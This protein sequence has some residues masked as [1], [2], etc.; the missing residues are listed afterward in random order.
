MAYFIE[1]VAGLAGFPA[2][3]YWQ[4]LHGLLQ[5]FVATLGPD[6]INL[7]ILRRDEGIITGSL[8]GHVHTARRR[9]ERAIIRC[10]LIVAFHKVDGGILAAY[11]GDLDPKSRVNSVSTGPTLA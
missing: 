3:N 5:S 7:A 9:G 11:V 10:F 4:L 2:P 1:G 6:L 8:L